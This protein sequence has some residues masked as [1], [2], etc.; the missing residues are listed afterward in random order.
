MLPMHCAFR[1]AEEEEHNFINSNAAWHL[2]V[3]TIKSNFKELTFLQQ[4]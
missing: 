2:R 1:Y 4:K 3:I